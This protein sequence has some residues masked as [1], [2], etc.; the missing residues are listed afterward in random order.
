VSCPRFMTSILKLAVPE[1]SAH[2]TVQEVVRCRLTGQ[3]S[4]LLVELIRDVKAAF[5]GG[6]TATESRACRRIE[7]LP[8]PVRCCAP[9]VF[10]H[11]TPER[12]AFGTLRVPFGNVQSSEDLRENQILSG[13]VWNRG[14][15]RK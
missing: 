6:G 1:R 12:V 13:S 15:K 3:P 7:A 10:R 11:S 14:R 8:Y 9:G 4:Q 2:P 5:I